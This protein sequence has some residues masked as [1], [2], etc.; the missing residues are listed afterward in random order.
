V[1]LQST[2]WGF[3][4]AQNSPTV[5]TVIVRH[6]R[7]QHHNHPCFV[8]MMAAVSLGLGRSL[9]CRRFATSRLRSFSTALDVADSSF[10]LSHPSSVDGK[11]GERGRVCVVSSGKGGVGKTTVSAS[12]ALGLAMRG[13]ST[14]VVDFD[15]GLRNLDL[16]LGME[17]RVIFDMV[18]VLLGECALHQAVLKDKRTPK[19]SLLAASQTRDKEALT[20][21]GVEKILA[22]LTNSYDYV[23]LDSPAGIE[24]GARHVSECGKRY[25]VLDSF[26]V[27]LPDFKFL[28]SYLV[29]S[30]LNFGS[31]AITDVLILRVVFCCVTHSRPCC[32]AMTLSSSQIQS[33]VHSVMLTKWLGSFGRFLVGKD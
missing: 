29:W 15:I 20:V 18:H 2:P 32:F 5:V 19:L 8:T 12:F 24:S 26:F 6:H 4:M 14:C 1:Q 9:L 31:V 17:R 25:L 3:F 10:V 13:H 23:V 16:H 11:K 21:D 7:R 28:F 30:L 27:G 33:S 22:E